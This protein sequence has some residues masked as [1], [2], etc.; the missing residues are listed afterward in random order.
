VSPLE[1]QTKEFR[2]IT[3]VTE[4]YFVTATPPAVATSL[5]TRLAPQ[6]GVR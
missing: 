6:I 1:A 3:A 4:E 5:T 2:S